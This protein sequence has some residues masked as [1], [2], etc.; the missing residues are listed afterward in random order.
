MPQEAHSGRLPCSSCRACEAAFGRVAVVKSG[1]VIRQA[2]CAL[3]VYDCFAAERSLAS[4]A[5]ATAWAHNAHFIPELGRYLT[6]L[7]A[8][9]YKACRHPLSPARTGVLPHFSAFK[10][11]TK[12]H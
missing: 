10:I 9:S 1:T 4:S 12:I 5:A 3:R 6:P 7:W 8:M 2:H 11:R